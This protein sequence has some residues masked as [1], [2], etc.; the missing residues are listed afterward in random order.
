M[1]NQVYQR[2][3]CIGNQFSLHPTVVHSGPLQFTAI[4]CSTIYFSSHCFIF[5]HCTSSYLTVLN[6][7]PL[8]LT[9]VLRDTVV[10]WSDRELQ[11]VTTD[12]IQCKRPY[13][14]AIV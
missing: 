3:I 8:Y 1:G 13:S 10:G 5:P 4:Y 6:L 14:Y 2:L 9:Y 7:T 11:W 12:E